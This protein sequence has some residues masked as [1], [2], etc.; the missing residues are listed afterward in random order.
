MARSNKI[1]RL[2][3][4]KRPTP[5]VDSL[6]L[7]ISLQWL[8]CYLKGPASTSTI[9]TVIGYTLSKELF[10]TNWADKLLTTK[11]EG[12]S[13]PLPVVPWGLLVRETIQRTGNLRS[14]RDSVSKTTTVTK[15]N[16][17][18]PESFWK[19]YTQG[20]RLLASKAHTHTCSIP[21][22]PQHT[23]FL[24]VCTCVCICVCVNEKTGH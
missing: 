4:D 10:P 12:T 20:S 19:K 6:L 24:R 21:R 14:V 23:H 2:G 3:R 5:Q 1:G 9:L 16:Q 17:L 13:L 22:L 15:T 11:A 18:F 7:H 8:T